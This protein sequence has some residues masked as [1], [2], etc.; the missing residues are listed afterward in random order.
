MPRILTAVLAAFVS[1]HDTMRLVRGGKVC[2][3]E[4]YEVAAADGLRGRLGA[5]L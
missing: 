3:S 5:E 2:T 4:R 1:A